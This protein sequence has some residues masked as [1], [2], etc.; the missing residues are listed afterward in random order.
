MSSIPG[1]ERSPGE[2]IGNPLQYSGLENPM[3]RGAWW[4]TV[5]GIAKESDMTEQLNNNKK[6][7]FSLHSCGSMPFIIYIYEWIHIKGQKDIRDGKLCDECLRG[8]VGRGKGLWWLFF[9]PCFQAERRRKWHPTPVLLPGK[10]HGWR[11]LVGCSPWG[12]AELDTTEWL[13]FHFSLSC[14]GEGN[15]NPLQ[16]SCLENPRNGGAWWA[17]VYGVAHD[18]SN[19]AAAAAAARLNL[20]FLWEN[21]H[22]WILRAYFYRN[23]CYPQNISRS[24]QNQDYFK[25]WYKLGERWGI[26]YRSGKKWRLFVLFFWQLSKSLCLLKSE[27]MFPWA[28][29]HSHDVNGQPH[30]PGD[31]ISL[32]CVIREAEVEDK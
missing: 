1:L 23:H 32:F 3:D 8:E 31:A 6:L 16:C 29:L 18:W 19:L 17:A 22:R 2:G 28:H 20:I 30:Q 15:G 9:W 21:A 14:I 4:A 7:R 26:F 10:S 11:S 27:E 25:T 12:H 24:I 13:H 5:H